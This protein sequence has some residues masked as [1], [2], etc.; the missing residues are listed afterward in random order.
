MRYACAGPRVEPSIVLSVHF[1]SR[2]SAFTANR[3]RGLAAG[4]AA[5]LLL[6]S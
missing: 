5:T 6:K 1:D 4:A 3:F 2:C